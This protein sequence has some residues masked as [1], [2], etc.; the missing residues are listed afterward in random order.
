MSKKIFL[1]NPK[2]YDNE[3][4]YVKKCLDSGWITNGEYLEKFT[5]SVKKYTKAKYAIPCI[6][7]TSALHISL[8]VL[9][10]KKND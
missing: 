8:K 9:G 5:N 6:N 3:Y 2:I 10:I 7:G 1:H 4:T